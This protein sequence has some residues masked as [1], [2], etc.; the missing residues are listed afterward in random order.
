MSSNTEF[1]LVSS[2]LS[3]RWLLEASAGTGKTYSLEH[4]VA[5]LLVE[6]KAS[7]ERILLVTF[8]NAATNEISERV[9][10]LLKR[11]HARMQPDAQPLSDALEET[12]IEQWMQQEAD[13][14]AVFGRA[15]EAFDDASIL[16]IH[17]F[18]QKM[19]SE[20][21]F[22]RAGDYEVELAQTNELADTVV[23]EFIRSESAALK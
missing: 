2:P 23:E 22:T 18:C 20:F 3:G 7:I 15:L 16:T 13:L 17:K 8:T 1:N 11:M 21:S 5:R 6:R 4:L 10:Q 14:Q 12:L 9:R 19:L